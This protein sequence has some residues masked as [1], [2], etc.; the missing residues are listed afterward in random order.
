MDTTTMTNYTFNKNY[1]QDDRTGT[2]LGAIE[3]RAR[4]KAF[5]N[6]GVKNHRILIS[7]DKSVLVWEP[8]AGHF[9]NC[10][11]LSRPTKQRIIRANVR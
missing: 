2:F 3:V 10:N 9:S 6:E 5:S 8:V 11:I 1:I 4:C 7:A